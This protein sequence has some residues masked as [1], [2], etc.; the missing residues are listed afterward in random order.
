MNHFF[1]FFLFFF[2][3]AINESRG[4]R[5]VWKNSVL[6]YNGRGWHIFLNSKCWLKAVKSCKSLYSIY[7]GQL[8]MQIYL[9][10][11]T[12]IWEVQLMRRKYHVLDVM[13]IFYK[14]KNHLIYLEPFTSQMQ[15]CK[16]KISFLSWCL[17][18]IRSHD[19]V[20]H[21][22]STCVAKI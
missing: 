10:Q 15:R 14:K 5:K 7:F 11:T 18:L 19:E 13:L 17:Q 12:L 1:S 3:F 8:F 9:S 6:R 2:N 21:V 20:T 22:L 16:D 4:H